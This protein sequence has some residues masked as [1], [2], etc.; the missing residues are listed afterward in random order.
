MNESQKKRLDR[1]ADLMRG[2][3]P[4]RLRLALTKDATIQM[5]VTGPDKDSMQETA[6]GL[7]LTLTEYLVR[8]H[9]FAV[10]VLATHSKGGKK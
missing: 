9:L 4:E 1:L 8:L 7:G 3:D 2:T 10:E 6:S 5:R